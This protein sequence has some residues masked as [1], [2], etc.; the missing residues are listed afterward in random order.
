MRCYRKDICQ[1]SSLANGTDRDK[2][3]RLAT[4]CKTTPYDENAWSSLP[5]ACVIL[6]D[7]SWSMYDLVSTFKLDVLVQID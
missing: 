5:P 2:L 4:T 7:S 1:W 3:S 6:G